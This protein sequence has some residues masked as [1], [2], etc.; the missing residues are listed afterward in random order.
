MSALATNNSDLYQLS[1]G[2]FAEEIPAG[3]ESNVND[4]PQNNNP[5]HNSSLKR[6]E[7]NEDGRLKFTKDTVTIPKELEELIEQFFTGKI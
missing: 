5:V 1:F 4:T 6:I 2:D 7:N 3:H